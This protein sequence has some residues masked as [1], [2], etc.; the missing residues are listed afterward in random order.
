VRVLLVVS[1][2]LMVSAV[3][4]TCI[5]VM[6]DSP[7]DGHV[8]WRK[9]I[10]FALSF[11]ITNLTVAWVLSLLPRPTG[12]ARFLGPIFGLAGLAEV[13]FISLQQWRGVPSHF[14]TMASFDLSTEPGAGSP[15]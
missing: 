9:P 14:N 6:G 5:F 10:V 8:S 3:V 13:A 15:Q 2:I 4:H 11:A 12:A 7:W 1:G